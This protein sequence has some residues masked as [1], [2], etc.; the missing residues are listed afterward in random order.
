[1]TKAAKQLI[2]YI[3]CEQ[4]WKYFNLNLM[5]KFKI[6]SFQYEVIVNAKSHKKSYYF[7]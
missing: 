1:M 4:L 2:L 3:N 5:V 6:T 7:F